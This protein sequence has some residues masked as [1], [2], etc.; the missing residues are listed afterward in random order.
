MQDS[1]VI[2]QTIMSPDWSKYSLAAFTRLEVDSPEAMK[3][4]SELELN[5]LSSLQTAQLD[6]FRAAIHALNDHGHQLKGV[7]HE[8]SYIAFAEELEGLGK[9]I[10]ISGTSHPEEEFYTAYVQYTDIS[11]PPDF[12]PEEQ[13]ELE[14]QD[15]FYHHYE[16]TIGLSDEEI[17]ALPEE[18]HMVYCIGLLEAEINNGG[19]YQY[20]VNTEGALAAQTKRY[21]EKINAPI[22]SK[23]LKKAVEIFSPMPADDEDAWYEKL[24]EI[25]EKYGD[26]LDK[27]DEEYYEQVEN[28]AALTINYL[29]DK[30]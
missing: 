27:L 9:Q 12:S 7:E 17:A 29:N 18:R 24:D 19:F 2:P 3:L 26:E 23:L 28:L 21:L 4:M 1:A 15:E 6:G 5:L 16:D 11:D 30:K 10:R 25:D 8:G 22:A 13:A 20:F 14:L